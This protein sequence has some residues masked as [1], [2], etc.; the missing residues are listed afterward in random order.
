M[1]VTLCSFNHG[2]Q[3]EPCCPGMVLPIRSQGAPIGDGLFGAAGI[4]GS[5]LARFKARAAACVENLLSPCGE[6]H[7]LVARKARRLEV[8]VLADR[9]DFIT[10]LL[11]RETE[12]RHRHAVRSE[13]HT[14]E[15]QS[16][17]SISSAF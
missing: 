16:L 13:E 9:T 3:V 2:L 4:E 11:E 17:M 5:D 14:S 1:R 10:E 8:P 7:D 6:G 12:A 15:L